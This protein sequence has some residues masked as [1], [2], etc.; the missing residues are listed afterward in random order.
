MTKTSITGNNAQSACKPDH[1]ELV[2]SSNG[3]VHSYTIQLW[4]NQ[5]SNLNIWVG[6]Q[7]FLNAYFVAFPDGE[8]L[9]FERRIQAFRQSSD[10]VERSTIIWGKNQSFIFG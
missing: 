9:A 2:S 1:A 10:Y 6:G 3:A 4:Q 7:S 5:A 8:S